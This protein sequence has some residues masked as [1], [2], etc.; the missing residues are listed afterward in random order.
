MRSQAIRQADA[1]L[2]RAR[3]LLS[4]HRTRAKRDGAALDY[5]LTDVRQLLESSPCCNYC[6]LPVAWD[7]SLDHRTPTARGGRHA[8]DNLAVCCERCNGLKGQ[9]TEGEFHELLTSLA[10]L[11]PAARADLERRLLAG[12]RRYGTSPKYV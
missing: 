7:V 3:R 1:L 10:L 11:H 5:G 2:A 12:G 4:D 8:L 6:R 9:L